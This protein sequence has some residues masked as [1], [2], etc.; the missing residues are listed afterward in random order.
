MDQAFDRGGVAIVN[1]SGTVLK[2][3]ATYSNLNKGTAYVNYTC[4]ATAYIGQTVSVK[5][6]A[7]EDSSLQ[8]SFVVDDVTL[9]VQ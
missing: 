2:T 8:T 5:F 7:T 1:G 9:T 3:C 4:D 6:T